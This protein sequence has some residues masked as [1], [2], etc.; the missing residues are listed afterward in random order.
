MVT[1]VLPEFATELV[2]AL[3]GQD[4]AQLAAQVRGLRL[5]SSHC[6]DDHFCSS[7]YVAPRSRPWGPSHR[8]VPV[9]VAAGMV[10]LDVVDDV[11]VFVEVLDRPDVAECLRVRGE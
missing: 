1:E 7:F 8:N 9:E 4:D 5:E 10:I 3:L 2:E 11:I 6:C